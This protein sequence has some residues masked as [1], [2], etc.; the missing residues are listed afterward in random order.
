MT[1]KP[2]QR[3]A[4]PQPQKE[5][6]PDPPARTARGIEEIARQQARRAAANE[7]IDQ[8]PAGAAWQTYVYGTLGTGPDPVERAQ[9]T[10]A[11][12]QLYA[13]TGAVIWPPVAEK[14]EA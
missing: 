6:F 10:D 14:A 4:P 13:N 9:E 11:A 5:S 8:T 12:A 7:F 1:G 3:R 2:C